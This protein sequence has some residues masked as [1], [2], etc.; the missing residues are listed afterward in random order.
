MKLWHLSQHECTYDN[1]SK[2]DRKRQILYSITYMWNL[3]KKKKQ[4]EKHDKEKVKI[5]IIRSWL[6]EG[7]EEEKEGYKWRRISTELQ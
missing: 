1:W 7:L 5:Q 3:K 4:I 6:P 2:S